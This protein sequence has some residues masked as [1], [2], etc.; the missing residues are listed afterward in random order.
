MINGWTKLS[1]GYLC[2]TQPIGRRVDGSILYT[3]LASLDDDN[4]VE[5]RFSG[6]FDLGEGR[7]YYEFSLELNSQT[8]NTPDWR[9][10]EGFDR[11][12]VIPKKIRTKGLKKAIELTGTLPENIEELGFRYSKEDVLAGWKKVAQAQNEIP[13]GE[14]VSRGRRL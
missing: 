5:T 3:E 8:N 7:K 2:T 13:S 9:I 10:Y 12:H 11:S 1:K 6:A 14:S 4:H